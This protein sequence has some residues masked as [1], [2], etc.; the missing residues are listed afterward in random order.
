[1]SRAVYAKLWASTAQY[2]Q[3]RHYAWY[4]IWSRVIPWSVPWGIFAMWMVF[5]AM[6]VEYR[7]ALTFGIWQKPNIGTH[8]PD[9]ADAKK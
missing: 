3:R 4:Q 7:Q 5:P 2:T 9:P 6:P 8:G 1:M